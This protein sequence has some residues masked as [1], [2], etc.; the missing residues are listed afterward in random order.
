[1]VVTFRVEEPGTLTE[2]AVKLVAMSLVAGD[3]LALKLTDVASGLE[4]IASAA[5]GACRLI[6]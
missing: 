1:M 5:P 2:A 4:P 6:V 3:T